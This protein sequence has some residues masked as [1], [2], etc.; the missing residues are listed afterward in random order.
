MSY[1]QTDKENKNSEDKNFIEDLK[2]ISEQQE[3]RCF[4]VFDKKDITLKVD[5]DEVEM[6]M[7]EQELYSKVDAKINNKIKTKKLIWIL[8][9]IPNHLAVRLEADYIDRIIKLMKS[10]TLIEKMKEH[11]IKFLLKDIE[12][13]PRIIKSKMDGD[14]LKNKVREIEAKKNRLSMDCDE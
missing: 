5:I 11:G 14:Y 10:K 13:E 1:I 6:E 8:K 7:P 2:K 9:H 12:I 4:I 3:E